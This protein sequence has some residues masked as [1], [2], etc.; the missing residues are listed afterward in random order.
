ME[1]TYYG[2][3]S[4]MVKTGGKS[5]LFDPFISP[6]PLAKSIDINTLKPDYILISHGHEDHMADVETIAKNT[7]AT[8]ISNF[9]II[10][11]FAGKGIEKGHPMNFGGKWEFD[12]GTVKYVQAVHSSTMP[13]GKSGGHP[14]GFVIDTAEGCFYYAG[15]TSL[16][17]DM[18]LIGNSKELGF[19]MLPVGDNFTMGIDDAIIASN[20]I[21]CRKIIGMHYDT[22][23]YIEIDHEDAKRKFRN[24]EKELILFEIGETREF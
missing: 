2:H 1:I 3:A 7:G 19:A 14:G 17:M 23:G 20:Y 12:F 13:D 18:Q 4:Y 9:E 16:T 15:D 6:N 22:F 8:L 21:K 24:S 10:A 11:W 5:L